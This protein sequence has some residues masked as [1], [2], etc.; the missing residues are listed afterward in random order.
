MKVVELVSKLEEIAAKCKGEARKMCGKL[1][2]DII[3]WDMQMASILKK[4]NKKILKEMERDE[5]EFI[6]FLMKEG[7]E[8]GSIGEA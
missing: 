2:D 5:D 1:I 4:T 8:S 3:E 6:K 7:I